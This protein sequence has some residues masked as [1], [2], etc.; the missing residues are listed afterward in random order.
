MP[1]IKHTPAMDQGRTICIPLPQEITAPDLEALAAQAALLEP[2]SPKAGDPIQASKPAYTGRKAV[3]SKDEYWANREERDIE[4]DKHIR[5]SG[6]LQ[7]LLGSVNFGQYCTG[8][9]A[10]DYLTK[11]EQAALRLA[12]FVTEN[13]K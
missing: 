7:A 4:K 5:L 9:T 8:T 3:A 6:V 12:K 11:A 2:V 13:A 10:E 1:L